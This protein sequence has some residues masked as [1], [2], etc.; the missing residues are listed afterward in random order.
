MKSEKRTDFSSYL[1][2]S[3]IQKKYTEYQNGAEARAMRR[4][5]KHLTR[6]NKLEKK[7]E[8]NKHKPEV[9]RFNLMDISL[10][11]NEARHDIKKLRRKNMSKDMH[12]ELIEV[13]R[14]LDRFKQY[15]DEGLN[16]LMINQLI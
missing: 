14:E 2:E 4:I 5:G 9:Q 8:S 10:T 12:D 15:S 13:E 16:Y 1:E 3:W 11:V 6:L 7:A